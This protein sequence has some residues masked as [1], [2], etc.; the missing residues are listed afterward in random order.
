M[1]LKHK[2]NP[3]LLN[4]YTIHLDKTISFSI[5]ELLEPGFYHYTRLSVRER[6]PT[7]LPLPLPI[8]KPPIKGQSIKVKK[9]NVA[10]KT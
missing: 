7:R 4:H 2:V 5:E 10:K 6:I 8:S 1:F 9:I 3:F